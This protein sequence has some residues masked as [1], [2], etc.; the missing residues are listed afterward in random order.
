MLQSSPFRSGRGFTLLEILVVL[1][2]IGLTLALVQINLTPG[3]N[4]VINDETLRLETVMNAAMD[5]VAA[6]GKPIALELQRSGYR[7]LSKENQSWKDETEAPF[8][9]HVFAPDL[10]WGRILIDGVAISTFPKR[11]VWQPGSNPPVL[12]LQLATTTLSK[13]LLLDPLGRV[14]R[15]AS[16]TQ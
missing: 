9:V 5:E 6:G 2:I 1:M 3:E 4:T 7:F 11:I 8:G 12:D 10:R 13:R 16:Q 14:Q 15:A